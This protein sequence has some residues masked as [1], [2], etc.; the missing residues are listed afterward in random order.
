[1]TT[2]IVIRERQQYLLTSPRGVWRREPLRRELGAS[3]LRAIS[4]LSR[5]V[6]VLPAAEGSATR[7]RRPSRGSYVPLRVTLLRKN[8]LRGSASRGLHPRRPGKRPMRPRC[9][10]QEDQPRCP[11][12]VSVLVG[13]TNARQC[14]HWWSLAGKPRYP[15]S[16]HPLAY[17]R[18]LAARRAPSTDQ[19]QR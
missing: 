17:P 13:S 18:T 15:S 9:Q 1:M 5:S 14:R 7:E 8:P 3:R 2:V 19:T 10:A 4:Q 12:R 11:T 6:T 16:W